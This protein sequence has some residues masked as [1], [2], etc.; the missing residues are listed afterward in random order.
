VCFRTRTELLE[1]IDA[2][3]PGYSV[4]MET[5]IPPRRNNLLWV[6]HRSG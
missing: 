1:L 4:A 5:R 3:L 2:G 6:M